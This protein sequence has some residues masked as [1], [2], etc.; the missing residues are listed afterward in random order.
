LTILA[1]SGDYLMENV[2]GVILDID[3]VLEYQKQVFPGAV[4]AIEAFRERGLAVRFLTNSTL[5]SRASCAE[6]L[7]RGGFRVDEREVITASSATA[8]YL[9]GLHPTTCWVLLERAGLDE[10]R[11]FTQDT[12]HP[13]WLVVGDNRSQ[14]NFDVLNRALGVLS[15]GAGL[16]GMQAELVDSSSGTLELNVGSWVGMLERASGVPAIYIGKPN[17]FVFDLATRSMGLDPSDVVMIGDRVA[18]DNIGA[19]GVGMRSILVKT[20]EFQERDLAGSVQP[21]AVCASILEVPGVLFG[22]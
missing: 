8:E 9:R 4:E 15:R 2:R 1:K 19:K 20:G 10:F 17:R 12:E 3:G 5:K 14:F 13:E 6:R 21:D 11:E 18:T 16:I 22:G 7:R